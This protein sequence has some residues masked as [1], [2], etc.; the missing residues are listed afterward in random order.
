MS[1]TMQTLATSVNDPS[2]LPRDAAGGPDQQ[3]LE[4]WERY[5]YVRDRGHS[6]YCEKAQRLEQYYLGGGEQWLPED[7]A[8]LEEQGRRPIEINEIFDALNNAFG[9]QISNRLD[10]SFKPR[11]QGAVE[12]TAT[13]LSKLAMQIA[14]ATRLQW[15]ET[16]VFSDGMIQQRGYYETRLNF[17]DNMQGEITLAVLD[18]MDV[19]PDPDAKNYDPDTW[20]DVTV[21]RW[22]S[23]DQIESF[24]SLRAR[25]LVEN[26][27]A[28]MAE[29]D[30][31]EDINETERNSFGGNS[32]FSPTFDAYYR[33]GGIVRYRIIDRQQWKVIPTKVVVFPTGDVRN[34]EDASA[35]KIAAWKKQGCMFMKRRMRRVWWSASTRDCTL[36]A[37]WSPYDH[38]TVVP[39]FAYFR[40]GKTRGGVD[41]LMGPQDLLN[42]GVSQYI[43][44]VNVTAN[45]GWAVEEN[46]LSGD[47][48]TDDLKTEGAKTGLILEYRKGATPPKRIEAN[49]V[50]QG[51]AEM[52][53]MGSEKIGKVSGANDQRDGSGGG[54]NQSGTAIQS[55]QF[56]AQMSL[57]VP[58][59]N[60]TKTRHLLARMWLSMI[61]GYYD[62]PR[63]YRITKTDANG[64]KATEELALNQQAEDGTILNDLTIGD[65]DVVITEQ[66]MQVTF[67]NSQYNQAIDMKKLGIGI[68]D[69]VVLRYSNLADKSEVIDRMQQQ[70]QGNPLDEA[71]A[72]LA[73]AQTAVAQATATAKNVEA[74]FSAIRTSQIIAQM[75]Q[76]ASIADTIIKSAG[77]VDADGGDAYGQPPAQ[78]SLPAA[79]ENTHPAT[80]DNPQRGMDT[81][82]EAGPTPAAGG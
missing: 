72:T 62:E 40:R 55:N 53:R 22:L 36:H 67:E 19:I 50:P 25:K 27:W 1:T 74:M 26:R 64:Q 23:L 29:A 69:D 31:G 66:P 37:A 30:F 56:A 73:Q 42:K 5:C 15:A 17:D 24:Y 77:F 12:A 41:N 52:I 8:A 75:P 54:A 65:Y 38:F 70:P 39:Y 79:P 46:S 63:I 57:A 11:G 13:A 10:I 43:H 9:F 45:G 21:T 4:N 18:P 51:I 76:A 80:P 58:L 33:E 82:I 60:L 49:A 61:Q 71:K 14:D 44:I 81:G 35:E 28:A 47:I 59:D 16:E 32:G 3:A 20:D 6:D 68:P 2:T 34:A 7:R 48:T 78:G